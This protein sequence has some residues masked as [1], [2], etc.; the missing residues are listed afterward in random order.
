[1]DADWVCFGEAEDIMEQLV[2]DLRADRRGQ[3][4]QGGAGT[5]MER[6]KIP[7]FELLPEVNDYATMALQFSRGCPFQCEFCDI[8]EIYGRVPRTKTPA[9]V[10]AEL[11]ALRQQGF[12]GYVS[13]VDDN[14]IGN[15]KKAKEMLKELAAWNRK[16]DHPFAFFTE[17]SINM[18]DDLELLDAM[19]EAGFVRVFIGIET[20]DPKLLRTTLKPQNIPGDLLTKVN[21]VREHGIHVTAGFIVG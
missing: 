2:S 3:R 12:K 20:P 15:K 8:I 9:Q 6:V 7:R 1:V 18:A 5:N 4:Y 19:V 16:H 13:M 14:F 10:T 21:R 17:A 11:E